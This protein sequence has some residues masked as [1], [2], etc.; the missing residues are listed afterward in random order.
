MKKNKKNNRKRP[1]NRRN[2]QN[3]IQRKPL[4]GIDRN[5]MLVRAYGPVFQ[6]Q[7]NFLSP[8]L[9]V[10]MRYADSFNQTIGAGGTFDYVFR[11]NSVRDPDFTSIGHQ[12]LGFDQMTPEYNKY[13]VD[14][15]D[16]F[17]TLPSVT[18]NYVAAVVLVNGNTALTNVGTAVEFPSGR[19]QSVGFNGGKSAIFTGHKSLPAFSGR[20]D[21]AYNIDN[22]TGAQV[23]NDPIEIMNLH[24]VIFNPNLVGITVTISASL[25]YRTVFYDPINPAPSFSEHTNGGFL[26]PKLIK[27]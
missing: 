2:D 3:I 6:N 9:E 18:V 13:R 21:L 7:L 26:I 4:M 17:I 1:F 19:F 5:R 8:W 23:G 20:S 12:P 27:N 24:V 25:K 10:P 22:T 14:R 15:L 16:W 11:A